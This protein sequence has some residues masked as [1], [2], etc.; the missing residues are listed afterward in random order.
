VRA[1]A[2]LARP[3]AADVDH[4]HRVAVLLAE[5]RHR[6]GRLGLV[7]GQHT[8]GH[9]QVVADGV[10]G[11]L[12]DL[13]LGRLRQRLTPR[14]VEPHVAG[15]VERSGLR[16]G[17][18]ERVAQGRVHEVG[19]GVRLLRGTA[20][21]GIHDAR[22]GLADADLA[23]RHLDRVADQTRHRALHVQHLELVARSHDHTLVGDLTAALGVQR[24]L[25]EDHLDDLPC[26]PLRATG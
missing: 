13:R 10:V 5:Q 12:L 6:A 20:V 15:A 11:D 8:R 25:G 7:E 2:Q 22:R 16:G 19:R 24:G 14:E 18:P 26:A 23:G 17:L 21:D 9:L 1:A 4:P 3:G